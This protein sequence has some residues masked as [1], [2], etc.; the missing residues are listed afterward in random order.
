MKFIA[1]SLAL[2]AVMSI[3]CAFAEENENLVKNPSFTEK[4]ENG[5]PKY[6]GT[7]LRQGHPAP[8]MKYTFGIGTPGRTDDSAAEISV[9][10]PIKCGALAEYYQLIQLKPD[11]EYYFMAYINVVSHGAYVNICLDFLNSKMQHAGALGTKAT[12]EIK[13]GYYTVEGTFKP[14]PE[15]KY[16]SISLR[17][18]DLG[19]GIARFDDILLIELPNP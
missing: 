13:D 19:Q 7:R 3:L 4:N 10:N 15:Q 11:T 12:G 18:Q 2:C 5:M 8:D 9:S 16:L 17:I 1:K 14:K 6:W